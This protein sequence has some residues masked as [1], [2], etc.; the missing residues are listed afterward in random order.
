[1]SKTE[2]TAVDP[3]DAAKR[4]GP[5]PLRLYSFARSST[6]KTVIFRGSVSRTATTRTS[7]IIWETS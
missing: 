1:M 3:L 4:F 5:D 7:P 2:G 6:D